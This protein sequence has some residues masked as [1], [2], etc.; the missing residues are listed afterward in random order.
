MFKYSID[1]E[2]PSLEISFFEVTTVSKPI[3]F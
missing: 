1:T 3:S 2:G